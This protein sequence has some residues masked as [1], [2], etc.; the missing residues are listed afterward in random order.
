[1][2]KN[3]KVCLTS[4]GTET[5]LAVGENA[6]LVHVLHDIAYYGVLQRL[7]ANAGR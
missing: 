1:M 2:L 7:T 4:S 3:N 5:V 6:V